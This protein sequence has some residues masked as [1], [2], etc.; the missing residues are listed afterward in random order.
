[1][2]TNLRVTGLAL[3]DE[4][5]LELGPGLTVITGE[6]GAGK[7]IMV[8]AL[9]LLRGGRASS[10]LIRDGADEARVEAVFELGPDSAITAWLAD[11]HD[12]AP[13]EGLVVRRAI[14]RSGRGRVHI[15]GSL[16]TAADLAATVGK[17]CAI[18]SQHD[19]QLL[20]DAES[21]LAILDAFV[22]QEGLL[23]EAKA[24]FATLTQAQAELGI[25]DADVRSRAER[26]DLLRFQLRELA[27]ANLQPGEDEALRQER[28]RG[29]SAEKLLAACRQGE[30][31]LYAAED[32]AAG[33]IASVA[34]EVAALTGLDPFFVPV[35]EALQ[36]AQ[37]QIEDAAAALARYASR[38]SLE[39]ERLADIEERLFL[40]G[41][42]T[43][44]HGGSIAAALERRA[45][46]ER[47]LA[48]LGSFADGLAARQAAVAAAEKIMDDLARTLG[49]ARRRGARAL[50][51]RIDETLRDLGLV[52]ANLAVLVEDRES[53][54][55][56]GRDRVKLA[57]SPNP[58]AGPRPLDR[59]ASG[60]ELSRVM[61]AVTQALARQGQAT[62]YVFDEVDTG[63]GGGT[64]EVIGRKLAAIAEHKQVLVVTHL[65]QIAAFADC[66]VKV[67]KESTKTRTSVRVAVLSA[68]ERKEE[69]ARM[70][71]GATPTAQAAAHAEDMLRRSKRSPG[72]AASRLA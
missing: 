8:E 38:L 57:F 58:G 50:G 65:A 46:I 41:R 44:K 72:S 22:G 60:G 47:E 42:I 19:Q 15:G 48:E 39:P 71:G 32:A 33:R 14:A 26:E 25:F 4:V 21:R 70:L 24:A 52:G 69:V 6:T 29:R 54:C 34:R 16:A 35:V 5:E 37:A 20:L 61:L 66:H 1:M 56:T 63:V 13:G 17:L 18:T 11:G 45:E 10:E 59:I 40:I 64:A 67:C 28:D 51:R 68:D 53:C 43:R 36:A 7:S 23:A 62:T 2:L 9:G 3:L 49:E 31:R 12:L 30:D 55:A 27:E